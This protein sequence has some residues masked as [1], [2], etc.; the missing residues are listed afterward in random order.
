MQEVGASLLQENDGERRF[1][2]GEKKPP[3][4][5]FAC[6]P[7]NQIVG[8]AGGAGTAG[9][10]SCFEALANQGDE[11]E[12]VAGG[13]FVGWRENFSVCYPG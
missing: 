1:Y 4:A 10:L 12:V 8:G 2:L 7:L 11:D 3:L 9:G 5:A 13:V 6:P